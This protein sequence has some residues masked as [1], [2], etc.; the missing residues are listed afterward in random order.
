MSR[1]APGTKRSVTTSPARTRPASPPR[2][3]G[4]RR[5]VP[6][7]KVLVLSGGI[8]IALLAGLF[9][10]GYALVRVPQPSS[11][12]LAQ[13]ATVYYNDGRTV[14]GE[15]GAR[16]RESV[17][18]AQIPLPVRRAVLAAEDRNFYSEPAVSPIG[19]LRAALVDLRHRD[20]VEG[21]STITQQ[22]VKNAF[23]TQDRTL[24]RKVKEFFIAIKIGQTQSKDQILENY[25]N[26][27]YF[28]RGAYGIE[29]AS[30]AYFGKDVRQLTVQEGA[31]LA[32]SI[33]APSYLDPAIHP[34]AAHDRWN[35]VLAGMVAKGWM[36]P[37]ERAAS[38]YPRVLPLT[39]S[40]ALRGPNG[41]LVAAVKD[42]LAAHG[43]TENEI[44]RG[45]M[46]IVTTF[47][48]K[49]Q[50]ALV[51]AVS[52]ITSGLPPDV[53]TGVA[54]VQPGTGAV[55]AM[56]G[57]PDYATRPFNDATQSIPP[58]GSSFKP[59]VLAAAL[60]RG[61]PLSATYD[62]HSPQI[63]GGQ[64]YVND[65]N[66]QFGRIDLVTATAYSVNTVYEQLGQQ[67]GLDRVIDAAHRAGLPGELS[68]N[69]SMLLGSDSAHPIDQATGYATFAADGVRAE[70]YLVTKVTDSA[71]HL[72]YQAKVKPAK[73]FAPGVARGVTYALRHVIS[74]GTGTA[75]NIGRPAAG[76]TGTTSGNVSAWFVGYTPQ[77]SAAVAMFRDGN[78]PL[79]N[80]GGYRQVYGGTLPAK[81]WAAFMTAALAGTP[82]TDFPPVP[83][84]VLAATP[85]PSP[86]PSSSPS[87]SPSPTPTPASPASPS[88]TGTTSPSPMSPPSSSASPSA[89]SPAA[90]TSAVPSPRGS[91]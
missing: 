35:Y 8:G 75:A 90:S 21:G 50:A 60:E 87:P 19:I 56:Y 36:T 65:N 73:A 3:T 34:Q 11:L 42:E 16:N 30:R 15:I 83:P 45:G 32:A 13:A 49:V 61:I 76:K 33:Q 9:A 38:Q 4:W 46:R 72:L 12:S 70:H 25:L 68:R 85:S 91:P 66:E 80:I 48:P 40:S 43:I 1:A 26:T 84:T 86:S 2:R 81:L 88:P 58:M 6:S 18:L 59:Y 78:A 17:P 44:N 69:G 14:L 28:G 5:W 67:V 41:Y 22:Y 57:G 20:F 64:R 47:D 62:G 79:V 89:G 10:L 7:W 77:L 74:E 51:Q 54:A 52:R 39:A 27:I 82:V 53:R 31:V 23:L 63:I 37:A 55:L 71:G 24:T 29:A